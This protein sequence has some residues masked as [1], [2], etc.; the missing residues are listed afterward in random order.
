MR[1]I[2]T[3]TL[4]T[5]TVSVV[6][7]E[8]GEQRYIAYAERPGEDHFTGRRGASLHEV[9]L[10]IGHD[11]GRAEHTTDEWKGHRP[12]DDLPFEVIPTVPRDGKL[13][14]PHCTHCKHKYSQHTGKGPR[15]DLFH[16]CSVWTCDCPHFGDPNPLTEVGV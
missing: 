3:Y 12:E 1:Q 14:D 5:Y 11:I 15:G 16:G 4:G 6:D 13:T 8:E 7:T 10:A 2:G 9:L